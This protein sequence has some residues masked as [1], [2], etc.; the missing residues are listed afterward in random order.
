MLDAE[1]MGGHRHA[2]VVGS[3]RSPQPGSERPRPVLHGGRRRIE[4]SRVTTRVLDREVGEGHMDKPRANVGKNAAPAPVLSR[5]SL[6][7]VV[8]RR[9]E[10]RISRSMSNDPRQS[11]VVMGT[12]AEGRSGPT[13]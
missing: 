8:W 10:P 3:R 7:S 4:I 12:P 1:H 13:P 5:S 2:R 6:P 11:I 9:I